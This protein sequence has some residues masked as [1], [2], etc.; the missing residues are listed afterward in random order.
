M[1]KELAGF[2]L[3]DEGSKGRKKKWQ[4]QYPWHWVAQAS[5]WHL[6]LDARGRSHCPMQ[7][8]RSRQHCQPCKGFSKPQN[9]LGIRLRLG[10]P[11]QRGFRALSIPEPDSE[12][13]DDLKPMK[14]GRKSLLVSK[15]QNY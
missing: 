14:R 4:V 13:G 10:R 3:T 2:I 12:N 5:K 11:L 15:T 1:Q 9:D 6:V 8:E 7:L